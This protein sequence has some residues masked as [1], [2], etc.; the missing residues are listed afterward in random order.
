[1]CVCVW[2]SLVFAAPLT[3]YFRPCFCMCVCEY[4]CACVSLCVVIAAPLTRFGRTMGRMTMKSTHKVLG[5]SLVRSLV[6]SRH[7]FIR[8]LRT[9]RFARALR[10]ARSFAH[11]LT[12]LS[13]SSFMSNFQGV[14]NH[15]V[16]LET[17]PNANSRFRRNAEANEDTVYSNASSRVL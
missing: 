5:Y 2:L 17:H 15:S 1:M 13:P 11:L 6:H 12:G 9:S 3:R 14:L 16:L 4:V 10:C 7:T 8:S